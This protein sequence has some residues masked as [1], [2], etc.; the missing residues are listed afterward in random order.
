[1]TSPT[2]EILVLPCCNVSP[3]TRVIVPLIDLLPALGDTTVALK[4][5]SI[6]A[7]VLP[8]GTLTVTSLSNI[9]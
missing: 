8:Y 4:F 1:M 5:R 3:D 9:V 6:D 7:V 2:D